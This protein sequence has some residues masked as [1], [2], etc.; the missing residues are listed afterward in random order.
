MI[1]SSA[2]NSEAEEKESIKI[3]LKFKRYIFDGKKRMIQTS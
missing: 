3:Y 2:V 1:E